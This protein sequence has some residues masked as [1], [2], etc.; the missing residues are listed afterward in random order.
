M[1]LQSRAETDRERHVVLRQGPEA[2][3]SPDESGWGRVSF[4]SSALD[5]D[6]DYSAR[7]SCERGDK[8]VNG[9]ERE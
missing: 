6:S 2:A 4:W 7:G 1:T 3:S 5:I 8:E 9:I